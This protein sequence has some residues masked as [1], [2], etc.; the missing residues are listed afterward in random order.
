MLQFIEKAN[1]IH[2]ER[3]DYSLVEYTKSKT[4]VR[5]ICPD[6][7]EFLSSPSVHLR[8]KSG[9]CPKCSGRKSIEYFKELAEGIHNNK[10]DYSKIESIKN[11]KSLLPIVCNNHESPFIFYQSSYHH[12]HRKQGCP[13]C[14]GKFSYDYR[15]FIRKANKIHNNK[16]DY[17]FLEEDYKGNKSKVRIICKDHGIFHQ[18]PNAHLMP[19]GCNLCSRRDFKNI[20]SFILESNKIHNNKYGYE[21]VKFD[22]I[23]TEVIINCPIHGDFI[24]NAYNHI[25]GF[26][27]RKCSEC[28]KHTQDSVIQKFKEVHG[29]KYDYSLVEFV[30]IREKVKIICQK[31]GIFYQEPFCHYQNQGCPKCRLSKGEKKIMEFLQRN[32]IEFECQKKFNGLVNKKP[33]SFDF[34]LPKYNTCIEFDGLQH[35]SPIDAFGGIESFQIL[36][37]ND[38]KKDKFCE[39]NNINLIRI[40]YLEFELVDSILEQKIKDNNGINIL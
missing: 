28:E 35:F 30:N 20:E 26:G 4:K 31:H 25:L 8:T 1:K 15:E 13:L 5:I 3:F 7:G 6:H 10:Y 12:I 2:K 38:D 27:C 21:K 16:Y 34:Y 32:S 40:S 29:E 36:K 19:R 9:G 24:Q 23:K 11:S 33:L 17:S 22:S 37:S 14:V 18:T 39:E